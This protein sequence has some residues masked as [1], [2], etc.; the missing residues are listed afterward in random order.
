MPQEQGTPP[1]VGSADVTSVPE[2]GG[3]ERLGTLP[4]ETG[5]PVAPVAAILTMPP[6][7]A[8][9]AVARVEATPT[10]TSVETAPQPSRM[11]RQPGTGAAGTARPDPVA[12]LIA[13]A[14]FAAYTTLSVDRYL[15]LN[16]GSWD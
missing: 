4:A 13:L 15:R 2:P 9:P 11:G 3:G 1:N 12:W 14:A 7:E 8:S 6:V 10:L 16:P 5:P